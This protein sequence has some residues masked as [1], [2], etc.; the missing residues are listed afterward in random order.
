ML[1]GTVKLEGGSER[2]RARA[3]QLR[4]VLIGLP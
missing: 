4:Q 2:E 1:A 3:A